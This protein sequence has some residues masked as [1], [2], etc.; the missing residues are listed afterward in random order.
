MDRALI[1]TVTPCVPAVAGL[2]GMC[3][4]KY[5]CGETTFWMVQNLGSKLGLEPDQNLGEDVDVDLV[6][7]CGSV[8][9]M[10]PLVAACG[11]C[12]DS[13]YISIV[14]QLRDL[15]LLLLLLLIC[16][17]YSQLKL[18]TQCVIFVLLY[19]FSFLF[20]WDTL[21]VWRHF[22]GPLWAREYFRFNSQD[23][24]Q[25]QIRVRVWIKIRYNVYL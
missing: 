19:F 9:L 14:G 3:L 5:C 18:R 22:A 25:S 2:V 10:A 12:R 21:F 16:F 17:I 1:N 11:N 24:S 15:L 7:I 20:L 13:H 8:Y 23:Y 6:Y 4:S